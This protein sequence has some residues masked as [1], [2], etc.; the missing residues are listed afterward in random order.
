MIFNIIRKQNVMI[1]IFRL[2]VAYFLTGCWI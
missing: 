1:K 2:L